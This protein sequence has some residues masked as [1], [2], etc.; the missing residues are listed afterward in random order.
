MEV[1]TVSM[2]TFPPGQGAGYWSSDESM[3]AG[4]LSVDTQQG[5]ATFPGAIGDRW[6]VL[7][8]GD[9]QQRFGREVKGEISIVVMMSMMMVVVG[10]CGGGVLGE[11]R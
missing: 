11:E 7:S 8:R 9:G 5:L 3:S 2:M 10:G 1:W 6:S 4:F